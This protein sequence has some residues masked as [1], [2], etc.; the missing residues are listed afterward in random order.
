MQKLINVNLNGCLVSRLGSPDSREYGMASGN[1]LKASQRHPILVPSDAAGLL[2]VDYPRSA[3]VRR[4]VPV[5]E[6]VVS[7]ELE[8]LDTF[9]EEG[10]L[11]C[12]TVD[13]DY[14][15]TQRRSLECDLFVTNLTKPLPHGRCPIGREPVIRP[16]NNGAV[17]TQTRQMAQSL[18]DLSEAEVAEQSAHKDEVSRHGTGV[19][20][21]GGGVT[22][23]DVDAREP[24]LRCKSPCNRDIT[25][26]EFDESS[27]HVRTTRM[28]PQR[29]DN[30]TTLPGTHADHADGAFRSIVQ[31]PR[32]L[33]LDYP[34]PPRERGVGIVVFPV[35]LKPVSVGCRRS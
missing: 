2:R 31:N 10:R 30:V 20:R 7:D 16:D 33:F 9:S 34:Q 28:T 26:V 8:D 4:K 19:G 24:A 23:D 17:R 1:R 12:E 11:S 18:A 25:R 3:A 5:A 22:G 14:F 32:D 29:T 27:S 35:P 13:P 21:G 15:G 6:L